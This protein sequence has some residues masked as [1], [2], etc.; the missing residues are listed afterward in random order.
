[1][2]NQLTN[3]L[4]MQIAEKGLDAAALRQK[5]IANNLA[6]VDTPGYKRSYVSFEEELKA[7]LAAGQKPKLRGTL[8]NEKHIPIGPKPLG[9][10][11]PQVRLQRDTS[12]RNDGNNVNIDE[13]M[14]NLAKNSIMYN[15]LVQQIA[16]EFS[17][18]RQVI[19]EGRR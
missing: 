16:G 7:A 1:M 11:K 9:Q 6:N 5:V 12:L 19:S 18:L 10:I 8:T 17:K 13:E 14:A 2:I 15:A 4:T 3:T